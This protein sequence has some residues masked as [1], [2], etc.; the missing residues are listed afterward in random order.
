MEM[1]GEQQV[2]QSFAA[3]ST[4]SELMASHAREVVA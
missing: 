2:A 1:P 4:P 3:A